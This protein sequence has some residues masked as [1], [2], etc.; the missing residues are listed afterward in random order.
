MQ[1]RG[2]RFKFEDWKIIEV[3]A[4]N[5]FESRQALD[6]GLRILAKMITAAYIKERTQERKTH[7][8]ATQ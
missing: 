6:N 1:K 2:K 8:E 7:D 5:T 3:F 4:G